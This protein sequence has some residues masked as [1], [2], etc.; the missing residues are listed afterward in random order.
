MRIWWGWIAMFLSTFAL[1]SPSL[2]LEG[3]PFLPYRMN[4]AVV[5]SPNGLL[6][7][8][9]LLG[10]RWD[11]TLAP[12]YRCQG[13]AR[14]ESVDLVFYLDEDIRG[15]RLQVDGQESDGAAFIDLA[16]DEG[17]SGAMEVGETVLRNRMRSLDPP[18]HLAPDGDPPERF[19]LVGSD[20]I[21]SGFQASS[22]LFSISASR[23]PLIPIGGFLLIV[24]ITAALP[25][26][27]GRRRILASTLTICAAFGST[28]VIVYLAVPRP[29]LF[30]VAF[31]ADRH[32]AKISGVME[33]KVDERPGYTRVAY[34]ARQELQSDAVKP[35][36]GNPGT[37]ELVGLWAPTRIGVPVTDIVPSGSLVRFI[38][39]PLVTLVDGVPVL[40][41]KNFI[42]G[43]VVHANH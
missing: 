1:A 30:S 7:T 38:S 5:T 35:E 4:H 31:A 27:T 18:I 15:L 26:N 19:S 36:T 16:T 32:D 43:W 25:L 33:R 2:H 22:A 23:A 42:T 17:K 37:V 34:A 12:L 3:G 29:T 9:E 24:L 28:A 10:Q 14:S 11:G 40:G 13:S 21:M 20:L 41:S 39:P 8:V 6:G